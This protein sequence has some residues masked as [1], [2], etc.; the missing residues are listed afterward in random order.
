M[1]KLGLVATVPL[2]TVWVIE[3]PTTS[4]PVVESVSVSGAVVVV[5]VV[6]SVSP[7]VVVVES[8]V[9]G[10]TV[11]VGGSVVVVE[12]VDVTGS[13]VVGESVDVGG[14]DVGF[15]VPSVPLMERVPAV[16]SSAH[17][18]ASVAAHTSPNTASNRRVGAV[19][20]MLTFQSEDRREDRFA[21][22]D[23]TIFA[24]LSRTIA[25]LQ[26]PRFARKGR[27]RGD[28][29][30]MTICPERHATRGRARTRTSHATWPFGQVMERRRATVPVRE[31]A[32][33]A[34]ARVATAFTDSAAR[35]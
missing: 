21:S 31:M 18:A 27:A 11:V 1:R 30:A 17:P 2:L 15:V 22:G 33:G 26:D 9:V 28:A 12:S 3:R 35:V 6:V 16:V 32:A 29:A 20:Y 19:R 8:V 25:A 23:A 4:V 24:K 13:V 7:V 34:R 10:A 5:A 14:S